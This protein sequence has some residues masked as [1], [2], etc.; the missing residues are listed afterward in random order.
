MCANELNENEFD[1]EWSTST[2]DIMDDGATQWELLAYN[3]AVELAN[4]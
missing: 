2:S 3:C 1:E 4:Q